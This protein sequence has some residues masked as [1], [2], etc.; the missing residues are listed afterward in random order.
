MRIFVVGGAGYI[1][2]VTAAELVRAG[3]EVIVVDNLATGY[4]A[5]VP[6]GATFEEIDLADQPALDAL[7]ARATPDGVIHFAASSLVGES[8]QKPERYFRNNVVNTLNLLETMLRYGVKRLVF[9]STAAVYGLP[10]TVPIDEEAA[11]QPINPY[12]RSKLMIEQ[13]L[14][15]FDAIHGLRY[16]ALRY[17]NAAGA[18]GEQGEDH[19]PETHLIPLILRVALG[20]SEA[21][22]IYGTDYAT[23]DGTAIRDYVH[24]VDLAHAH[25]LALTALD[26]G[27]RI[28]NLGSGTGF[29]VREV[30]EAARAVT[31]HPIPVIESPRR[32]GDPPSLIASRD[33]IQQELGWQLRYPELHDIIAHA[34]AWHQRHPHGYEPQG[35][36]QYQR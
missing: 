26:S 9:S 8:M 36:E 4:R 19:E 2:S 34:W 1:G 7:F 12:G 18:W 10:E 23:P 25:I 35:V 3:H 17:F 33:K 13:M 20:Q 15:W 29:S 30:I 6:Q 28:Y 14:H 16:A 31:G 21:I 22:R 11:Q 32:A 27:S 24:V 5:A